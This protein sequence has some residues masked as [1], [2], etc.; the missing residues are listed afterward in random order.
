M[1]RFIVVGVTGLLIACAVMEP[2]TGGPEDT[3]PP[4]VVA[5][6]PVPDSVGIARDTGVMIRFDEKLDGDSFKNRIITY[7]PL[8]FKA[9][10]V[11]G[12][13]VMIEFEK[14]LPETTVTVLLKA[15]YQD[16]HL[17]KGS[18]PV[19]FS[20]ATS[21]RIDSGTIA[22]KIVF[23]KKPD[24]TGVA[25][26]FAIADTTIDVK[27][28]RE[29]RLAFA[30]RT[31][32]FT[33]RAVPTDSARFILWA[34]TDKNGD[35]VFSEGSEFSALFP[36]TI[37]LTGDRTGIDGLLIYIIDP[38]EPGSVDGRVVDITGLG[39]SP[40]VRLTPL[41]P[42]ERPIVAAADTTGNFVF[43]VIPPGGYT[44][45]VFIDMEADSVCGEY[46]SPTDTTVSL[47]EPCYV[48]PDTLVVKP[49]ESQTLQPITLERERADE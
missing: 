37:V 28:A 31:G 2:P 38:S 10:K 20:F 40:M 8:E 4:R 18:A 13:R 33:F 6:A 45:N 35:G 15:G 34:F 36:D 22:G 11:K 49:G 25:A 32:D 14:L 12:E 39:K 43:P 3:I 26:I 30:D 9:I 29:S 47:A 48:H 21:R 19:M 23:K 16:N 41:L 24:S 17:V 1:K 44:V 27:R 5:I 7:P 46:R 42:G